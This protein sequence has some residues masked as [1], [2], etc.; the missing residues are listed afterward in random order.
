MATSA[1]GI[2]APAGFLLVDKPAGMTSHDVVARSRRIF[3]TRK[4]G[5]AG[6]LDPMATGVLILG[7]NAGTRLLG[8]L[9]LSDKSYVGAIRLGAAS[10]TDDRE[11]ELGPVSDSSH[12][13]P[14]AIE[15]VLV[16]LRGDIMQRPSSVSAIKI[17]GQR[18]HAR[19]RDGQLVEIPERKVS[20]HQLDVVGIT[21]VG[22]FMDI[23]VCTR[24][25]SGTYI[26]ALARDLG[27]SLG[28]GGHLT[29]LRRTS[30][31]PFKEESCHNLEDL[32]ALSDPWSAVLPLADIAKMILPVF[33]LTCEQSSAVRMG[34]RISWP[35][36]FTDPVIALID[37]EGELAALSEKRDSSCSYI[38]VFPS[39]VRPPSNLRP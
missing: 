15:G 16:T 2:K 35:E 38:A 3:A 13:S 21:T 39:G 9:S 27:E 7:V 22:E 37:S 30:I 33:T 17:D 1:D 11:G 24:V 26:R 6:T 20:V 25:S 34:Q 19:V 23:D 31:G 5:H 36:G 8:H 4:I 14:E 18:A 28:V 32:E 12:V 10:S 29:S